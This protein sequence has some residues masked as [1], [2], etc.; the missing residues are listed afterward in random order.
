M[1]YERPTISEIKDRIEKGI[2]SRLFGKTALLRV[3]LLRILARVFAGSLHALYGYL[4]WIT[5]QLFVT[6]ASEFFLENM[7]GNM[8]RVPRK[9]GS[10]ASGTAIFSGTNGTLID[11]DTRLQ[12]DQ[13]IEY[14]TT[15]PVTISG[16]VASV[17]IQAIESGEDGNLLRTNPPDPVYLQMVSTLAGVDDE[18][19]I[20]GDITGGIDK[21]DLED[22][23]SRILQRIQNPPAGGSS[24]DYVRWATEVDGVVRAW[25]Y[26]LANG[27][28]TVTTVITAFGSDP[29]P[30]SLLVSDTQN[31]IEVVRPVTADQT[32][33]SITDSLGVDGK[34]L[35]DFN[36]LLPSGENVSDVQSNIIDNIEA[37][38][39]PHRPGTTV[40]I[41]Q[42]RSAI[43]TSGVS[44]YTIQAID[45]DSVSVFIEDI[46]LTG[47]AY[48]WLDSI[49]FGD[50]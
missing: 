4:A 42:I 5:D 48:P 31:H 45:V 49:T 22:Y 28:G 9:G 39:L 34:A 13:G 37:L 1:A 25:C 40:P 16:G 18:V 27:P 7:H 38:F 21:E 8:W 32:V 20:D 35:F 3:A 33:A 44:D 41:S 6:T 47:Y 12:N 14:G 36:I 11:T 19:E 10:F 26:P 24:A 50:L 29:V 43:S 15:L 17:S 30:S 46:V 2:E 23:R